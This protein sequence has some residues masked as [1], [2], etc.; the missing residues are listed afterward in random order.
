MPRV[1]LR[2]DT[3]RSAAV[4]LRRQQPLLLISRDFVN[5]LT[6]DELRSIVAHE[7][8][9]IAFGDLAA[10]RLAGLSTALVVPAILFVG[11]AAIGQLPVLNEPPLLGGLWAITS[12]AVGLAW[13]PWRRRRELRADAYA[14]ALTHDTDALAS[15]LTKAHTAIEQVRRR[16]VGPPPLS[17][18]LMPVTR[19]LP[20]H[21]SIP[22]RTSRLR[23][24]DT[25]SVEAL[26]RADAPT[27]PNPL[28]R[29]AA[30]VA[31][32][33][34]VAM[35][36]AFDVPWITE[37]DRAL[38]YLT[39]SFFGANSYGWLAPVGGL[40]IATV[41]ACL[42]GVALRRDS[43]II[44]GLTALT[45]SFGCAAVAVA[46]ELEFAGLL[47][48]GDPYYSVAPEAGLVVGAITTALLVVA[49]VGLFV[50][51]VTAGRPT[52]VDQ[53]ASSSF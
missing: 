40:L 25:R 48:G 9:H 34:G 35:L 12:F 18:L 8:G 44:L 13:A 38:P 10:M 5:A 47:R 53:I 30:L 11:T 49:C 46:K 22:E 7:A 41:G 42:I 2:G 31:M 51:A 45:V 27:R 23:A 24:T 50:V 52:A 33:I 3:L 14:A 1:S 39:Y 36:F 19:P 6:D 15:A 21:P 29:V 20:T 28:L 17:W 16:L 26:V 4:R 43:R 37:T 32:L